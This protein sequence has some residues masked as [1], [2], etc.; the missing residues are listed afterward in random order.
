VK[1]DLRRHPLK[2]RASLRL[3]RDG[4]I[5]FYGTNDPTGVGDGASHGYSVILR[6]VVLVRFQPVEIARA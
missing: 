4:S 1:I 2:V 3:R 5:G 6:H